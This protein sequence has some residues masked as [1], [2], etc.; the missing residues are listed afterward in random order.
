MQDV[1]KERN[2]DEKIRLDPFFELSPYLLCIA[3]YDGYFRRINPAVCKLL[4]YSQEELLARPI[5]DFI[6]HEDRHQTKVHRD[7]L[8]KNVPLLDFEN[9]YVTKGGEVVWLSWN[10]MPYD[11]KQLVYAIAKNIT[12]KKRIEEGREALLADLAEANKDLKQLNYTTS[13]DLRSPVNNL[14]TIVDLL[15]NSNIQSKV[16][17]ELIPILKS[18]TENLNQTLNDY[19]NIISQKES[20]VAPIEELDLKQ[21]LSTVVNSINSLAKNANAQFEIDFSEATHI[22]FNRA[23]LESIF[24]NL[25]TNSI[26]YR[27]L[28]VAPVISISSIRSHNAIQL[29]FADNGLGF[30]MS[31]VKGKIFGLHQRFHNHSDSKGIGLYLVHSHVTSLG[32]SIE[33]ASEVNK[34]TKFTIS[35]N[36]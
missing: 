24:L 36:E 10:S 16:A 1:S 12:H 22:R 5:S 2:E 26:K 20:Q 33:V 3:G 9:R 30:D 29:V 27:R 17:L 7:A 11:S 14:L 34:G 23:Y 25:I 19:L 8:L 21:V 6:Y 35:F 31:K 15:G 28:D 13:H 4:G 32:G 18:A